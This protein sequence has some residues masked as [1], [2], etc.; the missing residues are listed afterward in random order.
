MI[1]WFTESF[2]KDQDKRPKWM[3]WTK[4]ERRAAFGARMVYAAVFIVAY[5]TLMWFLL[6][7]L[8]MSDVLAG[9][10]AGAAIGLGTSI[11]VSPKFWP[12]LSKPR[13]K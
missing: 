9:G 6:F 2:A 3:S 10:T 11:L 12:L 5:A 4:P 8:N 1:W 7:R 13:Q